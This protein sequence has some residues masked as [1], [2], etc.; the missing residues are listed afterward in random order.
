M[1][2]VQLSILPSY[3]GTSRF[4]VQQH[5]EDRTPS[6]PRTVA[7]F[8]SYAEARRFV[9]DWERGGAS[10]ERARDRTRR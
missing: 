9:E 2:R 10:R 5:R 1:S 4:A 3:Q 7:A 8:D 6:F